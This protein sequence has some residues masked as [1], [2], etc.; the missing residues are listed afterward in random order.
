MRAARDAVLVLPTGGAATEQRHR[1][2]PSSCEAAPPGLDPQHCDVVLSPVF[3]Q[4]ELDMLLEA[5]SQPATGECK[6]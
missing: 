1:I 4:E 5:L 3:S 2:S 6:T